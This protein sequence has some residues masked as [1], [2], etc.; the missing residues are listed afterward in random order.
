[1]AEGWL[2]GAGAGF[3]AT[4]SGAVG[5]AMGVVGGEEIQLSNPAGWAGA[6]GLAGAERTVD[7]AGVI[8]LS[9]AAAG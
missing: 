8:Q 1:M 4:D 7:E 9:G 5:L 3:G 6:G 2:V